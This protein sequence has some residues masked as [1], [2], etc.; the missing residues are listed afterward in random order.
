MNHKRPK[1]MV[2]LFTSTSC[3]VSR[4]T[5]S[6]LTEN[7]IMVQFFPQKTLSLVLDQ[8]PPH[9]NTDHSLLPL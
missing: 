8:V 1:D 9:I 5:K 4:A 7:A 3:L 2:P 6:F